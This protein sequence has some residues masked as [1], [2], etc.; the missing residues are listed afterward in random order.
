MSDLSN[1]YQTASRIFL[2]I[3]KAKHGGV[4]L[5]EI[6]ATHGI[7]KKQAA[8]DI[9][10]I[11]AQGIPLYDEKEGYRNRWHLMRAWDIATGSE[12]YYMKNTFIAWAKCN[13]YQYRLKGIPYIIIR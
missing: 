1:R 10:F 7:G 4:T 6:A 8:R 5:E 13:E 2:I 9:A 12:A 11:K 3:E